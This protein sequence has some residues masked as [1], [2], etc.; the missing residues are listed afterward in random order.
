MHMII[1]PLSNVEDPDHKKLVDLYM[2]IEIQVKADM[3]KMFVYLEG[4]Q[5]LKN[6]RQDIEILNPNTILWQ[7]QTNYELT[8][9]FW[10]KVVNSMPAMIH[11]FV[12]IRLQI[13][14]YFPDGSSNVL[15]DEL[16]EKQESIICLT[17]K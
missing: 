14:Q 17:D 6:L 10:Q 5:D 1:Q 11:P 15:F 2:E 4:F 7:H 16:Y 3:I 12:T 13:L 9:K 8:E